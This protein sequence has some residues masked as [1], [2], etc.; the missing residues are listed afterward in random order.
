MPGAAA[1]Q[2]LIQPLQTAGPGVAVLH[3]PACTH[4]E[5]VSQVGIGQQAFD[6][7][8]KRLC[9]LG[10]EQVDIGFGLHTGE[11]QVGGVTRF[12]ISGGGVITAISV[13][14][15]NAGGIAPRAMRPNSGLPPGGAPK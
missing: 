14:G 9:S 11:R 13:R 12:V 2:E 15:G 6:G 7:G 4:P 10:R 1:G 3:E 5:P 8:N